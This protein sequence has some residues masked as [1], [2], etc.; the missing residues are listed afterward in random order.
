MLEPRVLDLNEVL[1]E[2]RSLLA[3]TLGEDIELRIEG[4]LTGHIQ[5]DR[6]QLEQI[7]LNLVVNARDAMP[8]GGRLTIRTYQ[9]ALDDE[10]V[11]R[12]PGSQAGDFICLEVADTG[13]G[14]SPDLLDYIFEP[15]FTTKAP[16]EG[17]GL[18]LATVYG[19][20]KQSM[21]YIQVE[22][23]V[24]KG[25]TFS[26]YFPA[27]DG[28]LEGEE[29]E[30]GAPAAGG[31]ETI[32]LVE[33]DEA[34]RSLA[35]RVL[36]LQGYRVI[37]AGDGR[38]GLEQAEAFEGPIHLLVTDVIMP[39]IGGRELSEKIEMVRPGIPV[40]FI[41]GYTDDALLRHGVRHGEVRMLYKPFSAG[42]FANAVR[43]AL[44][45]QPISSRSQPSSETGPTG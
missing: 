4:E 30:E 44:A 42:E 9:T 18:G 29:L 40:L 6:S 31:G 45:G 3:R 11:D 10:F 5:V 26:I 35:E 23:E 21:G 7:V 13:E 38:E 2:T 12:H 20:V 36:M 32:L 34:V 39:R 22:S 15:F 8:Q 19:I 37:T 1:D 41:S 28:I 43:S 33:D 17:T 24:G 25:T 27:R 16:G 14:M